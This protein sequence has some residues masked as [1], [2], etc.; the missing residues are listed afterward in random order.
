M[1]AYAA[2][3]E[4]LFT[5][6]DCRDGPS[7]ATTLDGYEFECV[8]TAPDGSR[9]F[10]GT[11]ESGLLRSTDTGNHWESVGSFENRVTAVA[12]SPHDA[13]DIW[14]GTEPS[15]VYRSRDGGDSWEH[16][17]GLTN[18]PSADRWSFPPRPQTHHVRWLSVDPHDAETVYVAIEAGA[19]VRT[20]DGGDTWERHPD[21]AR[22]DNHTL[23]THADV[24]G[25]VYTAAG[26]GY[27]ESDSAGQTWHYPQDGLEHRYVW[28]LAVDPTDP[29]TVVVSAADS[30]RSAHSPGTADAHIYRKQERSWDLAMDG[31]PDSNGQVR[32]V[33]DSGSRSGEFLAL[34]NR[35]LFLSTD[36][37]ASW[38]R[39]AIEWPGAYEEQVGRGLAV[40]E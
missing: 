36:G 6:R 7:V 2:L 37:A 30:A 38:K 20:T 14:V 29:E 13:T 16:C 17:E 12:V 19:F 21:G 4:T 40:V 1:D 5:V 24:E 23:E 8:A 39:L 32:A 11:V 28:G 9:A 31:L 35:G 15:A 10:A 34:T 33:L 18:L 22:R 27:A 26:D 25:R 3:D